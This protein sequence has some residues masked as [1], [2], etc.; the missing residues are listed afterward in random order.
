LSLLIIAT[1]N[2][3]NK[4]TPTPKNIDDTINVIVMLLLY[5][6]YLNKSSHKGE[7]NPLM[8]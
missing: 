7:L 5:P 6:I 3:I 1:A 2:P 8:N 4:A